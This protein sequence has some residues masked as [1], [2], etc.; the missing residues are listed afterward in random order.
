MSSK[1]MSFPPVIFI[2]HPLAPSILAASSKGL[3][4]AACAASNALDLPEPIP[5]PRR[6]VPASV[7]TDLISAKSTL[8][9]PGQVIMSLIPLT[10]ILKTSSAFLNAS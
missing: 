8:T 5:I 4:I 10:P 7:M 9:N 2:T 1:V 3:F 6:A